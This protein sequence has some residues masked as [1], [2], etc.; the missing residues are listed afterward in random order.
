MPPLV[1]GHT[2]GAPPLG[3]QDCYSARITSHDVEIGV[4]GKGQPFGNYNNSNTNIETY[5]EWGKQHKAQSPGG[6]VGRGPLIR[7]PL[8]PSFNHQIGRG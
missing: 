5:K 1:G 7:G 3:V 8:P 6:A 4:E 2:L